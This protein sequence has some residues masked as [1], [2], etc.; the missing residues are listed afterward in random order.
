MTTTI[1]AWILLWNY[2]PCTSSPCT[3]M[4]TPMLPVEFVLNGGLQ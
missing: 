1:M 3:E 2:T 4:Y